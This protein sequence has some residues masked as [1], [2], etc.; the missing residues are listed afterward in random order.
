VHLL[1]STEPI[2][3]KQNAQGLEITR[4]QAMPDA[5]ANVFALSLAP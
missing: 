5:Q 3:W 4:P 1:N 2:T